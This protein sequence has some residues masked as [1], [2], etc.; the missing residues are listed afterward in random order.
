MNRLKR[1]FTAWRA[2]GQRSGQPPPPDAAVPVRVDG[3]GE[4]LVEVLSSTSGPWRVGITKDR[5]GYRLR[6]ETWGLDWELTGHASWFAN[7]HLGTFCDSLERAR[8][9]ARECLVSMG[10]P[11]PD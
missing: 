4:K 9:L 2:D 5:A 3:R 6:P 1:L 8:E 11:P 10:E 7:E